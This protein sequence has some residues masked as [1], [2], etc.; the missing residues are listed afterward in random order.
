MHGPLLRQAPTHLDRT[1]QLHRHLE[2]LQ[3]GTL[4]LIQGTNIT[5]LDLERQFMNDSLVCSLRPFALKSNYFM[6]GT[7][8][9]RI[10]II[11]C[12]TG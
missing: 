12:L 3:R 10:Q 7:K 4:P 5:N 8:D 9:G 11:N 6:V 2:D 1:R